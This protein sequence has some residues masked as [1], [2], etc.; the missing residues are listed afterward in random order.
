M[1]KAGRQ[2]PLILK[3]VA[4]GVHYLL[5]S[6]QLASGLGSVKLIRLPLSENFLSSI[7]RCDPTFHLDFC[8]GF[9]FLLIDTFLNLQGGFFP[10]SI[11][12]PV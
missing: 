12:T 4:R 1:H 11:S 3:G 10:I 7:F 8:F 2:R 5:P 9:S 6:H